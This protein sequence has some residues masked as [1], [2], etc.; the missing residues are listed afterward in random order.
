MHGR[1]LNALK[2]QHPNLLAPVCN[3]S[4]SPTIQLRVRLRKLVIFVRH[5]I[6]NLGTCHGTSNQEIVSMLRELA[7]RDGFAVRTK[8]LPPRRFDLKANVLDSTRLRNDTGWSPQIGLREGIKRM[9]NAAM[10]V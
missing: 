8:T 6:Y 2:Y 10:L 9:W 1:Y 7:E 4:A 3:Y 5:K